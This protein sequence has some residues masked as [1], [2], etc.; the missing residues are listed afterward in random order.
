MTEKK[1]MSIKVKAEMIE[2]LLGTLSG[3]PEL[4]EEFIASKHPSGEVQKDEAAAIEELAEVVEKAST[5]FPRKDGKPFV[6]DYQIKG[7][8]KAA[9]ET[10]IHTSTMTKEELKKVRLTEYLYKRT[11]DGLLFVSPRRIFLQLP[12]GDEELKFCQRPLRGQTMKGERIA[13]ARSE[14]APIGT[15]IEFEIRVLNKNLM[16]FLKPWL[17]YGVLRGLLQWRNSGM[18]RFEWEE[19]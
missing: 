18:G 6:F 19:M 5:Y 16:Q 2:P 4:A 9:C 8:I 13:L 3:N 11:L 10:M 14:M 12:N 15:K 7:F 1:E 17:D